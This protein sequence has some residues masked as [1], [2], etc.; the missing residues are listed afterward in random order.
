MSF[1]RTIINQSI[2]WIFGGTLFLGIPSYALAIVIFTFLLK[3]LLFPL[4]LTQ[5]RSMKKMQDLQ[6]EV[7]I[8]NEKHK[9]NPQKRQEE[10]AKLYQKNKVNAFAGC[11]PLLVQMPILFALFAALR[12]FVPR[13]PEYYTMH[14]LPGALWLDSLS[15]AG[16]WTLAIVVAGSTFWQQWVSTADKNN[17][18][19]KNMLIIMPLMMGFWAKSF[20]AALCIYWIVFSLMAVAQ[21]YVLDWYD[22]RKEQAE[23][24]RNPELAEAKRAKEEKLAA[25]LNKGQKKKEIPAKQEEKLPEAPEKPTVEYHTKKRKLTIK[26]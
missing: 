26:R 18:M 15:A 4:M 16:G 2:E 25:T 11:L 3:M 17:S 22:N 10:T 8:I 21:Q 23:L 14:L 20:P 19:Q 6:P 5:M 13:F 12:G 7:A 24:L 9:A 1:L